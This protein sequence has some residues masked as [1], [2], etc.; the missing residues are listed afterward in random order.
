M[1]PH[2]RSVMPKIGPVMTRANFCV[3]LMTHPSGD[4]ESVVLFSNEGNAREG[5][6]SVALKRSARQLR[7]PAL[8]MTAMAGTGGAADPLSR[9][10]TCAAMK[11]KAV[12]IPNEATR[13]FWV[14]IIVEDSF[15]V[16]VFLRRSAALLGV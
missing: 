1:S 16:R 11:S 14:R 6:A 2:P 8:T 15:P 7:I 9:G 10:T 13:G 5:N 3:V 12:R 4:D